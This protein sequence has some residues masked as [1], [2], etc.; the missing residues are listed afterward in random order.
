MRTD[1]ATVAELDQFDSLIDVRSPSEF[2][3]DRIPGALNLPVL[4]DAERAR[5]G[6]LYKQE[7]PFLARKVGAALVA[8]N[9]ARH[10][11]Q[12]LI[13]HERPWKPL[14][15]CW[16]GGK[17]SGSMTLVLRE[18]GWDARQL[19]GGYKAF[20][21]HVIAQLEQFPGKLDLRV[22][23][24][25]TGSGKS[26]LLG[27]LAAQGAQV[28]DLEALAA[29]RGSVLGGLPL[30]P[31]PSQKSFET[32]LWESMRSFDPRRPVYVESESRKIG[33]LRVPEAL[34]ARMWSGH[35]LRL[36]ADLPTR[37]RLLMAEYAHF[38][39]DTALLTE[40]LTT[41]VTLHGHKRIAEWLQLAAEGRFEAFVADLLEQHYDPAYTRS[42][43][44]HFADYGTAARLIVPATGG[45]AAFAGLAGQ[46][47]ASEAVAA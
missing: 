30:Q 25:L 15:Y 18:I 45:D 36:E 41:L 34:L 42:I 32:S 7:S 27:A 10:L 20:R 44:N 11:E 43:T 21:R 13:A 22:I 35:C 29:H 4:D 28:L 33:L 24:G 19:D 47:L 12:H 26:R 5:V 16:R 8:R 37:V 6:T 38:L 3:E 9:I 1:T 23:C 31:Q 17:R 2:A 40:K 46:L 39:T 14:V